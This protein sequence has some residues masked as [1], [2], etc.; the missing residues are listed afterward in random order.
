MRGARSNNW[1]QERRFGMFIHWGLYSIPAWH[2]QIQWRK[3][4]PKNVYIKLKDQFNPVNFDPNKW[5]D[6]AETAGMRYICITTKHHDGFCLWDTKAT[7]YNVMNTPYGKDVLKKLADAC[8]RRDMGLSLYYSVP[9]WHHP[10]AGKG[11]DHEL[12]EPNPGDHPDED[13]YIEFIRK[14]AR[15]LCT[16]YGKIISFWWDIPPKRRK[17]S[18]NAMIRKLQPGIM[19]NDRGYDRGD[20]DTPERVVPEGKRFSRPTEACQSV[21]KESWGYRQDE[22]YFSVKMLM[23]S[24]DRIMVMGGH[25]LLNIGPKADG[26]IPR[27]AKEILR[28]IGKWQ[29][30]VKEALEAEPASDICD[31]NDFMLTRRKNTLYVH[32]PMECESTGYHLNPLTTPPKKAILLNTGKKL[33]VKYEVLPG[34][35]GTKFSRIPCVHINGIPVDDL[36]EEVIVLKLEFDDLDRAIKKRRM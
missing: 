4:I 17:P 24:I 26:T 27:E 36:E 8:H 31:R 33:N 21:G 25:Y 1:S 18:I 20:F 34:T 28:K 15:E 10:N 13:R 11:G 2:E 32:F 30:K 9:D 35:F 19:I 22:D 14:Q 6:A 12:P 7:D 29:A 5:V 16:N 23:R 3:P